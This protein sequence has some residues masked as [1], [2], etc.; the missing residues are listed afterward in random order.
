MLVD[1][2]LVNF[3]PTTVQ[4]KS[5]DVT[6]DMGRH[7]CILCTVTGCFPPPHSFYC[8][9]VVLAFNF[10]ARRIRP[11]VSIVDHAVDINLCNNIV[12]GVMRHV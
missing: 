11:S 8:R 10:I 12:R 3:Q 9:G 1:H 2:S 4:D 5:P 7:S 6:Q